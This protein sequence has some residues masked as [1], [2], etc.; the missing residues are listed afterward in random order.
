[1]N[2]RPNED[3]VQYF[4]NDILPLLVNEEPEVQAVFVGQKP[5]SELLKLNAMPTVHVV[6]RVNDVRPYI[7]RGSV[8]IV[9]L[10]IGGGTRLKII[11]AMAMKK[12][13]VSTTVGAEG[14]DVTDGEDIMLADSPEDFAQAVLALLRDPE[15]CRT[16]GEAARSLVESRYG[17]DTL[18]DKLT[19]FAQELVPT[20]TESAQ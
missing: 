11:E 1:M 14:L 17:W 8:Y 16:L 4:V 12:A 15:R 5:S 13:V 2:W 19:L 3:C 10:R 20:P 6:G 18:A 7:E 9:P